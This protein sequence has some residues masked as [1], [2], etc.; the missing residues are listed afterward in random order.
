MNRQRK[1]NGHNSERRRP[2]AAQL[3]TQPAKRSNELELRQLGTKYKKSTKKKKVYRKI[4]ND[5]G[6]REL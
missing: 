6:E 1:A 3:Q 4:H 2:L 5:I